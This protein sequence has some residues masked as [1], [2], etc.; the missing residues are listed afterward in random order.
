MSTAWKKLPPY[1][2]SLAKGCLTCGSAHD[3]LP[4]N[5]SLAVGFGLVT[6][7]RDGDVVWQGDDSGVWLRRFERRAAKDPDHDWRVRFDAPLWDGV[8]QRQGE[9]HWVLVEKGRGFA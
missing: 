3:V 8:Y 5:S 7:T 6:V 4:L 2:G 9:A 1:R